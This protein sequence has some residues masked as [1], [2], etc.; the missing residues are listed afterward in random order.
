MDYRILNSAKQ[1]LKIHNRRATRRTIWCYHLLEVGFEIEISLDSVSP[2][3]I[4]KT[5][6]QTHEEHCEFFG[7]VL[8]INKCTHQ[9]Q[10]LMNEIFKD[11]L[12][13]SVLVFFDD[14]LVY[15]Q[16][17]LERN[18]LY[19]NGKKCI[20]EQRKVEYLGHIISQQGMV[21]D[22][23]KIKA[24]INWPTIFVAFWDC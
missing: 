19:L 10:A 24:M 17:I 13:S 11:Q 8:R 7:C 6:F 22:I 14:I 20:F 12:R 1:I 15:V 21:A 18:Q 5:D 4:S 2:T 16:E 23:Q 3:D 9:F